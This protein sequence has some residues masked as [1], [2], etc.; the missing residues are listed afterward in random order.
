MQRGALV[1]VCLLLLLATTSTNAL[2]GIIVRDNKFVDTGTNQPVMLRGVSHSSGEYECVH[3]TKHWNN[4]SN[5]VFEADINEQFVGNIKSWGNN[6]VRIPLNEDCWLNIN[7]VYTG[8]AKY[9]EAVVHFVNLLTKAGIASLLDLH[10][11]AS[12]S[13]QA[14]GQRAMPDKDHT[15]AFWKSV[16]QAFKNNSLALFELYNEPFPDNG[17]VKERSWVCLQTGACNGVVSVGYPAA[18]MNDLVAAVRSTGAKNVILVS[19]LV[20][21]NHLSGTHLSQIVRP[22]FA[23]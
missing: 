16:A 5:P 6:A 12:G 13:E 1:L 15:P 14:R 8:G 4:K 2:K 19:G 17:G 23:L 18:G 21:S 10:W 22:R 20:W 11:A 3:A 7:G 9:Q